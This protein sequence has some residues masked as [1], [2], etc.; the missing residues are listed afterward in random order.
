[1][2]E[3]VNGHEPHFGED[4]LDVAA[5]IRDEA[6]A[7]TISPDCDPVLR[8]LMEKCWKADPNDRPVSIWPKISIIV[9][10]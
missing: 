1:M 2:S 8:E 9:L 10:C 5:K 7:P 4:Q 3:I 6:Y